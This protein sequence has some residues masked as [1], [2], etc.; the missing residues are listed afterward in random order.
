M[1]P[2]LGRFS[3]VDIVCEKLEAVGKLSTLDLVVADSFTVRDT[4]RPFVLDTKRFTGLK[5]TL[6]Y[7]C[8]NQYGYTSEQIT[9]WLPSALGRSLDIDED[10]LKYPIAEYNLGDYAL[11][12]GWEYR[13]DS[14]NRK[15]CYPVHG[16]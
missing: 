14:Y 1:E 13:E 5:I 4:V 15:G 9:A 11:A 7:L 10:E 16:R 8:R 6:R 2:N 12:C 3:P